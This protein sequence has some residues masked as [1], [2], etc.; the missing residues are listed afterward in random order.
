MLLLLLVA[1]AAAVVAALAVTTKSK[2]VPSA[3]VHFCLPQLGWSSK[4]SATA[5]LEQQS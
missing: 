2:F 3:P 1:A 4:L 5:W